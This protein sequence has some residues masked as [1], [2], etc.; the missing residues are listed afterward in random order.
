MNNRIDYKDFWRIVTKLSKNIVFT[1]W[2][3]NKNSE[4]YAD[5]H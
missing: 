5:E 2:L 4:V 1:K 3:K